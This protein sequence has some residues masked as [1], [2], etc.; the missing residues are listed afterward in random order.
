MKK[1][2]VTIVTLLLCLSVFAGCSNKK[3]DFET[4]EQKNFT[5]T[6]NAPSVNVKKTVEYTTKYVYLGDFL[7]SEKIIGFENGPYGR[8]IHTVDGIS[9][10]SDKNLW[11]TLYVNGE[12]AMTGIDSVKIEAGFEYTLE[13]TEIK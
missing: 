10:N 4:S 13:L 7:E 12:S 6:I 5:L 8:F 1:F 2:L 11:W 3:S 9:D